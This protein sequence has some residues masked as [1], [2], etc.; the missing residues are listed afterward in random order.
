MTPPP[1]AETILPHAPVAGSWVLAANTGESESGVGSLHG[2]LSVGGGAGGPDG[3]EGANRPDGVDGVG[4]PNAVDGA[5]APDGA[6]SVG[7]PERANCV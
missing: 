6:D 4:G 7:E 1:S 2:T 3:V 5:G